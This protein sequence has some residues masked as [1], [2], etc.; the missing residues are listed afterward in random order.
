[1][2]CFFVFPR[3]FECLTVVWKYAALDLRKVW[4]P[5]IRIVPGLNLKGQT[6]KL[7]DDGLIVTSQTQASAAD[8]QIVETANLRGAGSV[9]DVKDVREELTNAETG[10]TFLVTGEGLYVV[11]R[12]GVEEESKLHE[13][14]LNQA[15]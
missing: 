7:G 13:N 11:R 8:Y 9:F 2:F 14:Q 15:G 3:G 1:M 4:A 10:T 5:A 12:P 6:E